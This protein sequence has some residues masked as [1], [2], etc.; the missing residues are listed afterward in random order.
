MGIVQIQTP[1]NE[2]AGMGFLVSPKLIVT[3]GHVVNLG[4]GA[5]IGCKTPPPRDA[6][7]SVLFPMVAQRPVAKSTV[8]RWRA[9]GGSPL[10]DIALLQLAEDAPPKAGITILADIVCQTLDRDPLSVFGVQP[11]RTLGQMVEAKFVGKASA[12]WVQIDAAGTNDLFIAPGYSGAAVWDHVH[13]AAVGMTVRRHSDPEVDVAYMIPTREIT[14]FLPEIPFE[15][16]EA[17]SMFSRA[18]TFYAPIMFL[19]VLLHFL[20]DRI[21]QFPEFLSLGLGNR[22][23]A[24]FVGMHLTLPLLAILLWM[25]STFAISF[26]EHPWWMRVPKFGRTASP[27]RPCATRLAAAA[28]LILFV[29]APLYAQ[30]HFFRR[31]HEEGN[32]Y[33]YVGDTFG[34]TEVDFTSKGLRCSVNQANP[35]CEYA[36]D[37]RYQLAQPK[38]GTAAKG[39][40]W[41]NAYHFGDLVGEQPPR[42]FTFFPILQPVFVAFLT[43]VAAIWAGRTFWLVFRPSRSRARPRSD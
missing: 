34:Y 26:R 43:F 22:A 30:V 12:A 15:K 23:M 16:R 41:Q 10:D 17:G 32:S 27:E 42:S 1:G 36:V 8:L 6:T 38:A 3:C 13:Q 29:A 25:L 14:S 33:I 20:A 37:G 5:N 31:F 35:L 11:G 40:Y 2:Q 21:G 28:S 24:N 19:F 18:W 9:P 4:I 7:V 39:G